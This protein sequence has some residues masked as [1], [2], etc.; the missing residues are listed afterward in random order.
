MTSSVSAVTDSLIEVDRE[1]ALVGG[2][3]GDA[4]EP[5][6]FG[7]GRTLVLVTLCVLSGVGWVWALIMSFAEPR[8]DWA[9]AATEQFLRRPEDPSIAGVAIVIVLMVAIATAAAAVTLRRHATDAPI[10]SLT[11]TGSSHHK[12]AIARGTEKGESMNVI[13]ATSGKGLA[14]QEGG[15]G[16]GRNAM[17]SRRIIAAVVAAVLVGALV[18]AGPAQARD[19]KKKNKSRPAPAAPANDDFAAAKAVSLGQEIRLDNSAATVE[20]GEPQGCG[21]ATNTVWFSFTPAS[22]ADLVTE[23]VSDKFNTALAVYVGDALESLEQ[24]GCAGG[25]STTSEVAFY[26]FGKQT[27]HFQVAGSNG[28]AGPLG[29]KLARGEEPGVLL[30]EPGSVPH[31]WKERVLLEPTTVEY[32]SDGADVITFDAAPNPANPNVYDI[33]ISVAGEPLPTIGLVTDGLYKEEHHY[34]AIGPSHSYA[35]FGMRVRYD[36]RGGQCRLYVDDECKLLI[37]NVPTADDITSGRAYRAELIVDLQLERKA[38]VAAIPLIEQTVRLP[39][40]GYAAA[41]LP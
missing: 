37:P 23:A 39:L 33:D 24:I 6:G 5:T 20:F 36:T 30:G 35:T 10:E 21:S 22:D 16:R 25:T 19:K 15:P 28:S 29:F 34:S 1:P 11:E 26:A 32:E 27:Y 8:P 12:S 3:D 13:F 7:R 41:F 40:V 31:G 18:P 9:A 2:F 38:G 14:R 17:G 4:A